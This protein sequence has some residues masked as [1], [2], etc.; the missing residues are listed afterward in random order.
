VLKGDLAL[1]SSELMRVQLAW[2]NQG[3]DEY[4]SQFRLEYYLDVGFD[5]DLAAA[6]VSAELHLDEVREL[7]GR[8]EQLERTVELLTEQL[9][10]AT[11]ES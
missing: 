7:R 9:E 8:I 10:Q 2:L 5:P 11:T 4:E 6:A 1:D 3:L